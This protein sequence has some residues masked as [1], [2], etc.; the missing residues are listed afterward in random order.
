M[1]KKKKSTIARNI[2]IGAL[3]GGIAAGMYS[4]FGPKGKENRKKVKE[5]VDEVKE[6][7][8]E[9]IKEARKE[10]ENETSPKE[11]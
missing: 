8:V 6:G 2:K 9:G 10:I 11:E 7:I 3:V 4:I 1:R 5:V